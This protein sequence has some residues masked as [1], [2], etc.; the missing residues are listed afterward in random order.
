MTT[1]K[2]DEKNDKEIPIINIDDGPDNANWLRI[3]AKRR[4]DA[5]AKGQSQPQQPP[6][7]PRQ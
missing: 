7:K 3:L 1:P 4:Q 5:Q 6:Q 2:P